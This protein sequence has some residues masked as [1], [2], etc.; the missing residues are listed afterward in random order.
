MMNNSK[1]VYVSYIKSTPE[2]LWQALTSAQSIQQY[3]AGMR[4]ESNWGVGS[5]WAMKFPDGRLADT[6]DI[7]ESRPPEKLVINWRNEFNPE[8]KEEGF[9]RCIFALDQLE[10][11]VKLTVTHQIEVPNSKFIEAV[12]GGWPFVISNLKSLLEIGEVVLKDTSRH[13]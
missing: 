5:P 10:G 13:K 6:G 3:W 8:L 1:F 12:S 11:V 2:K 7:I 9:S 4:A